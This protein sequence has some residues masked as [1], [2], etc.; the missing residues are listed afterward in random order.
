MCEKEV[1]LFIH[2]VLRTITEK[3]K[4][5]NLQPDHFSTF[6]FIP[7]TLLTISQ[8]SSTNLPLFSLYAVAVL[9]LT[10]GSTILHIFLL[11]VKISAVYNPAGGARFLFYLE[12][13]FLNF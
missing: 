11:T 7:S 4:E 2:G 5:I 8:N 3:Y 12:P 10:G 6:N 1:V 9:Y 13:E